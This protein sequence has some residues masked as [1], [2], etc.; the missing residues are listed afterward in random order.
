MCHALIWSAFFLNFLF[1]PHFTIILIQLP[2]SMQ[3]QILTPLKYIHLI[4]FKI[5]CMYLY[6]Y[7]VC[8]ININLADFQNVPQNFLMEQLSK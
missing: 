3:K 7:C 2:L 8:I 6:V 1:T 4:D 5:I